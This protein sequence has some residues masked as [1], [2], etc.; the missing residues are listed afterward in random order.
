MTN[1]GYMYDFGKG[2]E[3]NYEEAAK[4]YLMAANK[5]EGIAQNNLA[6]LYENGYGV[7]Q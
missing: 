1:I 3:V 2:V 4:W 6:L 7:E 5:G